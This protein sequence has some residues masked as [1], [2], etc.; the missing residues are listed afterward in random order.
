MQKKKKESVQIDSQQRQTCLGHN[1]GK[2]KK[3][4]CQTQSKVGTILE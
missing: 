3:Q 4:G 2:T 1:V